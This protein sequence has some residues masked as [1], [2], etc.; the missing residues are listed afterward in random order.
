MEIYSIYDKKSQTYSL[1]FYAPSAEV[2]CRVVINSMI[3]RRVDFYLHA[4][5]YSVRHLGSFD[6]TTGDIFPGEIVN[7]KTCEELA[8]IADKLRERIGDTENA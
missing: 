2:A 7:V 5:D 4:E 8:A 3:D 1:P 6:Q